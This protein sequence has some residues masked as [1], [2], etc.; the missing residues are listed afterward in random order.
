MATSEVK[1]GAFA[2]SGAAILAG[3]ISFMGAFSLG[4]GGYELHVDYPQVSGLMPG[5]EVRYAGVKVGSVKKINVSPDKVE[6]ITE[7]DDNIKIPEGASFSI[8]ADGIL[9]EKFVSVLPPAKV[10]Q[11]FIQQGTTVKGIAGGG[12][13]DLMANS[14]DVMSRLDNIA[15]AFEN[16]FGDKDVQ[17][18]LKASM[19]NMAAISDN[20]NEFTK[21]MADVAVANQADISN[22]AKQMNLVSQRMAAATAHLESMAAGVDANGQTGKNIANMAE[23]MASTT[24]RMENIVAVLEKV[25]QDPVTGQ[26]LKDTLV[27]VKETS[28]KANK[29]MGT[30]SNAEFQIDA[31]S[32]IK[33][34]DWRGNIGVNLRPSDNSFAYIGAYDVGDKNKMDFIVGRKFGDAGLSMGAMQGDFGVGLSY[35]F[36]KSFR[37]YSQLYDFDDAKVRVGGEIKVHD[38]FSLYGE[39]MDVRGTKK[40]TYL[41][42]RTYF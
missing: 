42:V 18:S 38:N 15:S 11:N 12:M 27:N 33:D 40:D 37:I 39:S 36:G 23:N 10:G 24:K 31:G 26:S 16:I 14:G 17:E 3:M 4:R 9:G 2:L 25:A 28:A 5:H 8:G 21:V 22:I 32:T 13:D 7:I 35:D 19:K 41:G 6:V 34:K 30:F 1:V 20:M 29:I